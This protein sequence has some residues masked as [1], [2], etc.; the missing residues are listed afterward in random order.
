MTLQRLLYI[1][2]FNLKNNIQ[3]TFTQPT[4]SLNIPR[5]YKAMSFSKPLLLL[6]SSQ[7]YT[8]TQYPLH[9][10]SHLPLSTITY[11]LSSLLS[12][13]SITSTPLLIYLPIEPIIL[14]HHQPYSL[15][16]APSDPS[17]PY[18]PVHQPSCRS[19]TPTS[20][21]QPI[22]SLEIAPIQLSQTRRLPRQQAVHSQ[23]LILDLIRQFTTI[24][25]PT[26]DQL[27]GHSMITR[28]L[29]ER[30]TKLSQPT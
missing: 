15:A 17:Y 1:D 22:R 18:L 25:H 24:P 2:V 23:L 6:N 4:T 16:Q 13:C 20:T 28:T 7:L 11:P 19:P 10:S 21:H 30:R 9:F 14:H 12:T 27:A 8:T 5:S 29:L 26:P 3:P